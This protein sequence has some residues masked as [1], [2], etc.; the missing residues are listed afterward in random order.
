MYV[1]SSFG[2]W[3]RLGIAFVIIVPLLLLSGWTI[4]AVTALYV[5]VPFA[6]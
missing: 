1:L 4:F 6:G 2:L 3:D 5:I